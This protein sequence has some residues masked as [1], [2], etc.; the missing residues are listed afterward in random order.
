M[1]PE[2]REIQLCWLKQHEDIDPERL[3]VVKANLKAYGIL[4]PIVIDHQLHIILDGHHRT[5]AWQ[6]LGHTYIPAIIVD[7]FDDRLI[8]EWRREGYE[9]KDKLD[10]V[11]TVLQEQRYQPK[12]TKFMW[13]CSDGLVTLQEGL[14]GIDVEYALKEANKE[15]R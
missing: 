12:T 5:A 6:L 11:Y 9:G 15:T 4:H 14:R 2:V 8:L 13:K 1:K 10:V 3:K 7:M